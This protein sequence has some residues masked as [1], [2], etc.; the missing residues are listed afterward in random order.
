MEQ[1]TVRGILFSEPIFDPNFLNL[2]F[3]F[4]QIILL[5][6]SIY[7]LIVALIE[8]LGPL[9]F[10][11]LKVVLLFVSLLLLFGIGYVL[12]KLWEVRE[13]E[14]R[15]YGEMQ[16]A[17]VEEVTAEE[18]NRRWQKVLEYLDSSNDSDWRL[19][20]LE[21]DSILGDLLGKM[22]YHGEN[23]G[24]QLKGVEISDFATLSQAW[25]AHKV[26]NKIA[27]EGTQFVLTKREAERV[28]TLY[29]KVFEEFHYI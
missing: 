15:T 16:T 22:G 6:V 24:E 27:H 12:Y 29:R 8:K 14:K 2:E 21:G 4:N 10:V 13:E 23:I 18:Q 26:R 19:A 20:I 9:N 17:A 25:E 11:M 1:E 7:S 5:G 3:I 28:V